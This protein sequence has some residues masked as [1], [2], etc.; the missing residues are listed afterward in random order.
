MRLRLPLWW[1]VAPAYLTLWTIGFSLWNLL[2]GNAMM[3]AFGVDTGGASDFIML[4][5]AAR[6]VAI[7]VAMILGV[8]VFRTFAS[9][10]TALCARLAMD[11]L[12]LVAGLQAGLIS[13]WTG[14]A[15]SM[16]L[17]LAPNG[18]A[19]ASLVYLC[20]KKQTQMLGG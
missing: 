2:D 4:N 11:L 18:L 7:G 15:Q 17:F 3:A 1:Y 14:L 8:W 9:I 6:Y 12:D 20:R 16:A 13:D 19:I 5:S 10:L